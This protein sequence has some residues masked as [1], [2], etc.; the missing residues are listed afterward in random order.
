MK[1]SIKFWS[2]KSSIWYLYHAKFLLSV[3]R[4]SLLQRICQIWIYKICVNCWCVTWNLAQPKLP[5]YTCIYMWE[6]L[7][8]P[9]VEEAAFQWSGHC[10]GGLGAC[11]PRKFE[12]FWGEFW[13]ILGWKKT[14]TNQYEV[15][16]KYYIYYGKASYWDYCRYTA[17]C[18]CTLHSYK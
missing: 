15:S 7:E 11:S 16:C 8:W 2:V 13:G 9:W 12:T 17:T 3:I 10:R 4:V 6:I 5:V 14:L 18:T 1:A